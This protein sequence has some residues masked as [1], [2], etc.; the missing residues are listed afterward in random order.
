M[1]LGLMLRIG[2]KKGCNL[3]KVWEL[4]GL[5]T[6]WLMIIYEWL[7]FEGVVLVVAVL[8]GCLVR[9]IYVCY[10]GNCCLSVHS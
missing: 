2:L 5:M 6:L 3:K 10:L 4:V 8:L 7:A 1:M 9:M